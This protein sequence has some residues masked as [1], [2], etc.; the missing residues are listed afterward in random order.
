MIVIMPSLVLAIALHAASFSSTGQGDVK[1]FVEQIENPVTN[2]SLL[3]RRIN[4]KKEYV[5]RRERK[6]NE[7]SKTKFKRSSKN[8]P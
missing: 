3:V 7:T 1:R 2:K 4:R 5:S 8:V 6:K